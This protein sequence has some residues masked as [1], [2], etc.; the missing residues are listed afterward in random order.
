MVF[1]ITL[2]AACNDRNNEIEDLKRKNASLQKQ[3]DSL[4]AAGKPEISTIGDTSSIAQEELPKIKT[5]DIV[6]GK[7]T[8][9]KHNLTLQWISWDEPGT[10][11]FNL[12]KMVGIRLKAARKTDYISIKEYQASITY[13]LRV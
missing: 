2:N 5:T 4:K 9:G 10:S 13:Q 12:R 3:T 7:L 1:V 6:K 11:P 8:P